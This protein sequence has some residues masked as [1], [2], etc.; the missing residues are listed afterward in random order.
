MNP[1]RKEKRVPA[2]LP[3]R[4]SRINEDGKPIEC[5]AHTLNLSRRGARLAG[6]TLAVKVGTV[7]RIHRGRASAYFRVMWVGSPETD[8]RFQVGVASV[9]NVSNFWGLEEPTAVSEAGEL[10]SS[11]RREFAKQLPPM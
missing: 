3:I 2:V 1:N 4:I 11:Q 10:Q 7:V 9:E 8:S 5:L 6:V